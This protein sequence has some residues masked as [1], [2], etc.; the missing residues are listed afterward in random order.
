MN[1]P[2]LCSGDFNELVRNSEK[3]GV[4]VEAKRRCNSSNMLL[5]SVVLWTLVILGLSSLGRSTTLTGTRYGKDLIGGW[6]IM[7][8]CR[9]FPGPL[10]II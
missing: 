5:M 4:A 2:W 1:L 9:N 7:N 8:G 3:L 10:S 6:Q